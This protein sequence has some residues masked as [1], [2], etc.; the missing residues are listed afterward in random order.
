LAAPADT[1]LLFF[2]C[3]AST[4]IHASQGISFIHNLPA[5][6][7]DTITANTNLQFSAGQTLT[8]SAPNSQAILMSTGGQ[9]TLTGDAGIVVTGAIDFT[10]AT[11]SQTVVGVDSVLCTC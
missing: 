3:I 1:L 9:I 11:V 10:A 7:A 4:Y 8:V 2:C 5:A 6:A